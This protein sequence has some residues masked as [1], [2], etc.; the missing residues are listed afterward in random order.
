MAPASLARVPIV[1][2]DLCIASSDVRVALLAEAI[3]F[4][5]S[6]YDTGSSSDRCLGVLRPNTAMSATSAR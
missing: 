6:F 5:V 2:N 1:T 4:L 3:E